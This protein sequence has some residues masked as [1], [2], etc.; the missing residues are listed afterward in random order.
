MT[1]NTIEHMQLIQQ[2]DEEDKILG[3]IVDYLL[4]ETEEINIFKDPAMLNCFNDIEKLDPK[5]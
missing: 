2:L 4:G 1:K 5:K 3:T